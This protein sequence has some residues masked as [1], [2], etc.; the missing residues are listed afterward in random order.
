MFESLDI[1]TL[2]LCSTLANGAFGAVFFTLWR[3][4]PG[5][6]HL[7]HWAMSGWV[8]AAVLIAF[9]S[10]LGNSLF[11]TGILFALVGLSDVLVVSGLNHLDG[12]PPFRR[13][14][15]IPLLPASLGYLIP[16]LF[17]LDEGSALAEAGEALGL[18]L[19]MGSCGIAVLHEGRGITAS[20]GRRI[21]GFAL[22]AYL[23]AYLTVV[24]VGI[25][26]PES[27]AML[28]RIPMMA[29]QL[30]LS[31]LNL[32]LLAIPA[33]RAQE[34]LQLAASRDPLTGVWNRDGLARLGP[35][36]LRAGGAVIA[37]DIDHFKAINDEHGHRSGDDVLIAVASAAEGF[38]E[39]QGGAVFRTGGDE[40]VAIVPRCDAV[41]GQRIADR[42]L[43]A[44]GDGS[45]L[46]R[47]TLSIGIALVQRDAPV[48]DDAI[49]S[50][51]DALYRAKTLGR[52]RAQLIAI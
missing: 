2:G 39:R 7:L 20:A 40:F 9:Y 22:L 36:L 11:A 27:S 52:N 49:K 12:Q 17:G 21:A 41:G 10:P 3:R 19:A 18:G 4:W 50:A 29:D 5:E 30:L 14:M 38:V 26:F 33:E 24:I 25:W 23:P 47:W 15:A 34:R 46:P 13:W 37:I 35:D 42:L 16:A 1:F 8:Y 43:Q 51:D 28:L 44:E 6:R 48:V 31:I 32:G 45:E